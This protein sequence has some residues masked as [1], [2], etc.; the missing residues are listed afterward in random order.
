MAIEDSE[1]KNYW[2]LSFIEPTKKGLN[3]MT[4]IDDEKSTILPNYFQRSFISVNNAGDSVFAYKTNDAQ[5][6]NYYEKALRKGNVLELI[7]TKK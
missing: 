1:F 5:L 4:V 6:I 2:S 3:L 7:R